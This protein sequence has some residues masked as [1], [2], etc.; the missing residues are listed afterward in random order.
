MERVSE[1]CLPA[2]RLSSV[3]CLCKGSYA[4]YTVCAVHVVMSLGCCSVVGYKNRICI[5]TCFQTI[6]KGTNFYFKIRCVSSV[7]QAA[8]ETHCCWAQ[9]SSH[10]RR[11]HQ[12][13]FICL[14][15]PCR[16]TTFIP[17]NLEHQ[18]GT[19]S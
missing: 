17:L 7:R 8:L 14:H 9:H 10:C 19:F 3:T 5:Q 16:A 13:P 4:L 15:T 1:I 12:Q 6:N 2:G 11:T 18:T